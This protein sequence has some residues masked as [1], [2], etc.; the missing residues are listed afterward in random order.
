MLVYKK[1]YW[2]SETGFDLLTPDQLTKK[3]ASDP[4]YAFEV[5]IDC[6]GFCP[7]VEQGLSMLTKGGKLCC[8]GIPPPDKKIRYKIQITNKIKHNYVSVV[9]IFQ[10]CFFVSIESTLCFQ[11][12]A[13]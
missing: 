7:A 2:V 1:K 3:R 8:F 9:I 12:M 13:T 4:D 10:F 11:H 6:S 5:V